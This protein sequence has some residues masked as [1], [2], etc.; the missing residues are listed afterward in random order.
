[1]VVGEMIAWP[2]Q[3]EAAMELLDDGR[4]AGRIHLAVER[5]G[6]RRRA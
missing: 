5:N 2:E 6:T 4:T 3:R 1:M